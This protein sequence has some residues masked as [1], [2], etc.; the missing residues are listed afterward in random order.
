MKYIII[1]LLIPSLT[2]AAG[3]SLLQQDHNSV[4][5]EWRNDGD[6]QITESRFEGFEEVSLPDAHYLWE[7]GNPHLPVYRIP[8]R[9]GENAR[10]EVSAEGWAEHQLNAPVLPSQPLQPQKWDEITEIDPEVY[11]NDQPYPQQVARIVEQGIIH[12]DHFTIVEVCPVQY[13][14]GAN[15]IRIPNSIEVRVSFEATQNR[16]PSPVFDRIK[17]R[18]YANPLLD[19]VCQPP[20]KMLVICPDTYQATLQPWLNWRRAVGYW[21]YV[22]TPGDLGSTYE[23]IRTSI[24][25]LY[26]FWGGIDYLILVGDVDDVTTHYTGGSDSPTDIDYGCVDGGDYVPDILIGRISVENNDQLAELVNRFIDYE[27]FNYADSAFASRY[28]FGTTNDDYNHDMVHTCHTYV[29]TTYMA[30]L[31]IGY[32]EIDGLYASEADVL[33]ALNDGYAYYYYY[34]HG[35]AN[36]LAAPPLTMAGVP[37]M[38]N[39]NK[40]PFIVGNACS[41]NDF[42]IATSFGEALLRQVNAGAIAYI[43]GSNST[44]WNPDSVWEIET[45]RAFLEDSMASAMAQCYEA[46]LEVMIAFP[47]YG[48]YFFDVYNLIGDPAIQLWAGIPQALHLEAPP[49]YPMGG[50][51]EIRI[52]VDVDGIPLSNARVCISWTDSAL[53]EITNETGYALF[54]IPPIPPETLLVTATA[55]RHIPAQ[56]GILPASPEEPFIYVTGI[57]TSDA[58]VLSSRNDG[59]GEWDFGET[60]SVNLQLS[61]MGI[62]AHEV[63]LDVNSDD[64][65][66]SLWGTAAGFVTVDS[67]GS[68]EHTYYLNVLPT[69]PDGHVAEVFFDIEDTAGHTWN[70]SHF[71]TFRA[72]IVEL[73]SIRLTDTLYGDG[74]YFIEVDETVAVWLEVNVPG[75]CDL[76]GLLINCHLPHEIDFLEIV[77]DY[78]WLTG[79]IPPDNFTVPFYL[80]VTREPLYEFNLILQWQYYESGGFDTMLVFRGS[81]G[82]FSSGDDLESW[83]SESAGSWSVID[84]PSNSPGTCFASRAAGNPFYDD[85]RS[86]ALVSPE[87]VVPWNASLVFW[88]QL[89]VPSHS[90][91]D[92]IARVELRCAEE[93]VTL[94]SHD[95]PQ[96]HWDL[97]IAEIP[98]Q[99]YGREC[100]IAFLFDS[101]DDNYRSGYMVDDIAVTSSGYFMGDASTTSKTGQEGSSYS[102]G[103]TLGSISGEYP[104]GVLLV[105]DGHEVSMVLDAGYDTPWRRYTASQIL[106]SGIHQYHFIAEEGGIYYRFPADGELSG[107]GVGELIFASDFEAD[108]GGLYVES[109]GWYRSSRSESHSGDYC[110]NNLG[111]GTSYAANLDARLIWG[112]D[113]TTLTQPAISFWSSIDFARGSSSG[114]IRDGG[115]VKIRTTGGTTM[116]YPFPHYHG[117]ILSDTNPLAGEIS[118]GESWAESW[119]QYYIDLQPWA[120]QTVEIIFNA[121]TNDIEPAT[122]WFLDDV[123]LIDVGAVVVNEDHLVPER[124]GLKVF[125]NPFNA[126]TEIEYN[127]PTTELV[128]LD[129]YSIDGRKVKTLINEVQVKGRHSV[130]WNGGGCGS[131][132]YFCELRTGDRSSLVKVLMLK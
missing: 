51:T 58:V 86:W 63:G 40:F 102:F 126:S 1:I 59:D 44:Y 74:D 19:P 81:P 7:V 3:L 131:G 132:L 2:L 88:Y 15:V 69:V 31:G 129:V 96:V 54:N 112:L 60:L 116:V 82:F 111:S 113:L 91:D 127:L 26:D 106:E 70:Y 41:T 107:P 13:D 105:I 21:I 47:D 101:D 130:I 83:T 61:N 35:S 117:R 46:L 97:V 118:Y 34:G 6:I 78:S 49:V 85:D 72:P 22:T 65:Y 121:G 39:S 73:V 4:L 52:D 28:L 115:N 93:E 17:E 79:I 8:L 124:F 62:T 75:G 123:M 99:Y 90:S 120:G 56:Y 67:E 84:D 12:G 43:G 92:D 128:K 103:V 33:A 108:D 18:F 32:M 94:W 100:S 68:V 5:L 14:P 77:S 23:G 29:N 89:Y 38:A 27:Q 36:G 71:L 30:P 114:L 110:W 11:E 55:F 20:A 95:E 57:T 98:T 48:H 25:A 16:I 87:F 125:P 37:T 66:V 104:R 9:T 80:H 76:N 122:G 50:S 45:F 64:P 42:T 109:T 10:L 119:Q 53:V 24:D